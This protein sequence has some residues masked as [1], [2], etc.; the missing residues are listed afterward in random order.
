MVDLDNAAPI[1]NFRIE[2]LREALLSARDLGLDLSSDYLVK[3]WFSH[4]TISVIY[5]DSNCGKS[6]LALDIAGH[7]AAGVDWMKNRVKQG[8]V[9]YLASEGG[10]GFAKRIAAIK[11]ENNI[12]YENM[13][14]NLQLLPVQV[15]FHGV[16]DVNAVISLIQKQD[17]SLI[18]VETLAMTMGAGS[19]N[20]GAV[21]GG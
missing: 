3:N 7:I 14:D 4:E 16:D 9:L 1:T 10:K 8:K 18:V 21:L 6:F 2:E 13:A 20:D 17:F 12:L 11:L 5:G 15:D 19:E